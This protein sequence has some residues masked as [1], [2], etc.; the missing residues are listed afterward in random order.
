MRLRQVESACQLTVN[1]LLAHVHCRV[2]DASWSW[3]RADLAVTEAEKLYTADVSSG[4][5]LAQLKLAAAHDHLRCSSVATLAL[6]LVAWGG[7]RHT[8]CA[9]ALCSMVRF[10]RHLFWGLTQQPSQQPSPG[11]T[12]DTHDLIVVQGNNNDSLWIEI[13][14]SCPKCSQ[15]P[16]STA[17]PTLRLGLMR[18]P[19]GASGGHSTGFGIQPL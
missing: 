14:T 5:E 7:G 2:N 13:P 3:L 1:E 15:C 16:R 9:N 12:N 11:L 18:R 19:T 17:P 4:N 6:M 10:R 8:N